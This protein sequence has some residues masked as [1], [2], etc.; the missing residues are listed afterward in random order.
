MF[1]EE[2]PKSVHQ[3]DLSASAAGTLQAIEHW[4]GG[5]PAAVQGWTE[6]GLRPRPG[7]IPTNHASGADPRGFA[8][9]ALVKHAQY[10]TGRIVEVSGYG[11]MRKVKI[12]FYTAGERS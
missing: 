9:G 8:E 11:A 12:R 4:R 1:L 10:G 3:V 6:A 2:L 7:P 5:G